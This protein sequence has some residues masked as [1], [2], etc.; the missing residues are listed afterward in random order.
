MSSQSRRQLNT[1]RSNRSLVSLGE[2]RLSIIAEDGDV[3]LP[4]QPQPTVRSHNRRHIR[5]WHYDDPPRHSYEKSPPPYSMWGVSGPAGEKLAQVKRKAYFVTRGGWRRLIAIAIIILA[6]IAGLIAG[7]VVGLKKRNSNSANDAS[8]S[9]P[10]SSP[11]ETPMN[12]QTF[13]LGSYALTTF[14]D[15]KAVDCTSNA[16]TWRCYPDSTYAQNPASQAIFELIIAETYPGSA[17]EN[18]Y[19]IYSPK[20]PFS[21]QFGNTTMDLVDAGTDNER[22]TFTLPLQLVVVPMHPITTD[23]TQASCYYNQTTFTGALYTKQASTF[24][25]SQNNTEASSQ[26]ANSMPLAFKPW[27]YAAQMSQTQQGGQNVPACY[28]AIDGFLSAQGPQI[29][30]FTPEPS[31]SMCSCVWKNY[32]P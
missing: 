2:P 12:N 30:T 10:A 32:D 28:E 11:S 22:Y 4:S 21:I 27:P 14:L 25:S 31:G 29:T 20:T 15:A 6:I 26:P 8:N 1:K 24:P 5:R 3:V 17:T 16:D 13:P 19:T 9:G 18:N 23:N 7:L